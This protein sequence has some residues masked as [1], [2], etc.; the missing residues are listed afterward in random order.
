M[1]IRCTGADAQDPLSNVM[2]QF[3]QCQHPSIRRR[4]WRRD[5]RSEQYHGSCTYSFKL[6]AQVS[7]LILLKHP[8]VAR[9]GHRDLAPSWRHG[10][11]N[12]GGGW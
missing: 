2:L 6:F 8:F 3:H 12:T 5:L 10:E 1:V 11:I 4:A 7:L 9:A